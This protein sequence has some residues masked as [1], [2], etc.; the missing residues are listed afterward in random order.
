MHKPMHARARPNPSTERGSRHEIPPLAKELLG[1]GESVFSE[2]IT[3][4]RSTP[5]QEQ[6]IL[7]LMDFFK[8][9]KLNGKKRRGYL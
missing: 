7:K 8:D 4:G 5:L 2:N 6:H 9:V 1:K 3:T